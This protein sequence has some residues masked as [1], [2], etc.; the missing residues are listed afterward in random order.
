MAVPVERF[1]N[2]CSEEIIIRSF[3]SHQKKN[4]YYDVLEQGDYGSFLPLIYFVIQRMYATFAYLCAKTSLYHVIINNMDEIK[5]VIIDEKIM[6]E[7][8]FSLYIESMNQYHDTE[9]EL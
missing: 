4:V 6:D 2:L 9:E 5:K 1:S 7:E 8:W 3:L